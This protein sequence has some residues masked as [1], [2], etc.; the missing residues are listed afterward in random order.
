MLTPEVVMAILSAIVAVSTGVIGLLM[1][2][3]KANSDVALELARHTAGKVEDIVRATN[4]MQD[5]LEKAAF[6]AGGHEARV[7]MRESAA[8]QPEAPVALHVVE[9]ER[10]DPHK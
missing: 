6:A 10:E 8:Y 4:G 5:K 3:I 1:A 9:T 2:R 7:Q